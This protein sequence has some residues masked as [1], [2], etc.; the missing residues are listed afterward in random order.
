MRTKTI[1][2]KRAGENKKWVSVE[3][4]NMELDLDVIFKLFYIN[5][6]NGY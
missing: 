1:F 2:E 4:N 6:I 3:D 5:N